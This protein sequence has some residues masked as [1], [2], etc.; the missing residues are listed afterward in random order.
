MMAKVFYPINCFLLKSLQL[1]KIQQV[2][3]CF[4]FQSCAEGE[5]EE[6]EEGKEKT[7][8][9]QLVSQKYCSSFLAVVS[10]C[11]IVSCRRRRWRSKRC[12]IS[13][14]GFTTEGLQRWCSR[15]SVPAK[16][17]RLACPS[18]F[19]Q[20]ALFGLTMM[21]DLCLSGRLTAMVTFTLKLGISILNGGNTLVQQVG[22]HPHAA[23]EQ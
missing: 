16:A 20:L 6:D 22:R 15:W 14:P 12:C 9:V 7:F 18:A 8:E 23:D 2:W 1:S 4:P 17:G 11:I 19:L 10:T 5:E 21:F 13:K 3:H